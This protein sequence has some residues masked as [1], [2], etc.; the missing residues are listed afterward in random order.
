MNVLV[1]QH[2]FKSCR[3]S[4]SYTFSSRRWSSRN[5]NPYPF[6]RHPNP[7]PHQI[8]HL[9]STASSEQIKTRYYELVRLYHPDKADATMSSD[10][11]HV[12]FQAIGQAYDIL[13]GKKPAKPSPAEKTTQATTA[14]R[15][16]MHVRRHRNL[17]DSGPVDDTW[18]D[19]LIMAGVAFAVGIIVIQTTLTRRAAINEALDQRSVM[20][21]ST[22]RQQKLDEDSRLAS[23][24]SDTT[25]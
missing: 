2:G 17:Y 25:P 16:A 6:P 1:S 7:S 19:R 18:K 20:T 12:R 9:S 22:R 11:A 4:L 21:Y 8:F 14:S 13:R 15:R 5:S 23:S 10:A 3:Y 24:S